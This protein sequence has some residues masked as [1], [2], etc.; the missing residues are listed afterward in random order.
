MQYSHPSINSVMIF[1]LL[2][3]GFLFCAQEALKSGKLRPFAAAGAAIAGCTAVYKTGIPSL[4]THAHYVVD[5][6]NAVPGLV[7]KVS[8]LE[9]GLLDVTRRIADPA[10]SKVDLANKKSL[11]FQLQ[12]CQQQ[13]ALQKTAMQQQSAKTEELTSTF[14]NFKNE[15]LRHILHAF[16]P[17]SD[18]T[19]SFAIQHDT[20]PQAIR[21]VPNDYYIAGDNRQFRVRPMYTSSLP[22]GC[23]ITHTPNG[24]VVVTIQHKR[25]VPRTR[26]NHLTSS[27]S[28][29][30]LASLT[31]PNSTATAT[32]TA[33]AQ[34]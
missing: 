11:A 7:T 28:T 20:I 9:D 23:T 10:N 29:F 22:R 27:P 30:D 21:F 14:N 6:A 26:K 18:L 34:S 2:S 15:T 17:K 19:R 12:E 5:Q 32:A 1:I 4:L 33:A 13:L 8:A 31:Q 16:D 3:N 25:G 24:M